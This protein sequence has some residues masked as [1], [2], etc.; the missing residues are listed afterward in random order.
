MYFLARKRS[1]HAISPAPASRP[2]TTLPNGPIHW[3]SKAN[4][5]NHAMPIRMA[6]IPIRLNHCDATRFS[7]ERVSPDFSFT[8]PNNGGTIGNA[9][10]EAGAASVARCMTGS[11]GRSAIGVA[12]VSIGIRCT[13]TRVTPRAF[14]VSSITCTRKRSSLSC[15]SRFPEV[16]GSI[17]LQL[18][19][20]RAVFSSNCRE[21]AVFTN[22]KFSEI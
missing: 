5:R 3:L 11:T 4:F 1:D 13:E 18:Y 22:P 6:K 16:S 20:R 21:W 9:G 2:M 7:S 12:A 15:S 17:A 14:S 10:I 19:R 8:A